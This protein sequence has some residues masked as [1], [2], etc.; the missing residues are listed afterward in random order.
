VVGDTE[1][2]TGIGFCSVTVPLPVC[3]ASSV[4][5]AATVTVFGIGNAAG[6]VYIPFASIVPTDAFP[7]AIEFTDQ[8]TALFANPLTAAANAS[9]APAR[10]VAVAGVTV[11]LLLLLSGGST[12]E[13]LP[14]VF[15]PRPEQ[16]LS[17][18][19]RSTACALQIRFT[20]VPPRWTDRRQFSAR[21]GI[22]VPRFAFLF[23]LLKELGV[24]AWVQSE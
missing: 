13:P 17:D 12:G 9:F 3:V 8:V 16:P 6:A 10:I 21:R 11:T 24:A 22:S 18:K 15:V 19:M 7:P 1:V 2:R 20:D 4:L 14:A 5:A 23:Q